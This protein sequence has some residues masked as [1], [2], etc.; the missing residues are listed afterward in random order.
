MRN[1][2]DGDGRVRKARARVSGMKGDCRSG[3]E[4]MRRDTR[5]AGAMK[6]DPRDSVGKRLAT[7]SVVTGDARVTGDEKGRGAKGILTV[8]RVVH[9]ETVRG[10]VPDGDG[11]GGA[12]TGRGARRDTCGIRLNIHNESHLEAGNTELSMSH[13]RVESIRSGSQMDLTLACG[14]VGAAIGRE[15]IAGRGAGSQDKSMDRFGRRGGRRTDGGGA[16][17]ALGG[18]RTARGVAWANGR[19]MQPRHRG[20]GGP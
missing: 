10:P 16:C 18:G 20:G 7:R 12:P 1:V 11:L 5:W 9:S 17:S 13:N 19:A 4:Q 6:R 3:R 8:D 14:M 2:A 15:R